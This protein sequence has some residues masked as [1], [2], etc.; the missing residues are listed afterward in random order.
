MSVSTCVAHQN[1]RCSVAELKTQATDDDVQAFIDSIA[2]PTRRADARTVTDLL[3]RL[4]GE[5]PVMWGKAIVGFGRR[6]LRYPNGRELDWMVIGF[7]PR[8]ASTTVY[9]AGEMGGYAQLLEQL[10]RHTVNGG[11]L[12]LKRLDDVDHGVLQQILA[13]SITTAQSPPT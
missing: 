12:H 11:C 6:V 3:G 10:G 9:L 5:P 8:K 2:D 1:K 4:T 7:A 13:R